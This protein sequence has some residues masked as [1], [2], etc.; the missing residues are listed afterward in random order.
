LRDRFPQIADGDKVVIWWGSVWKWLDA[1]TPI[2]AFAQIARSRSDVKFVITAGSPPAT[3]ASRFEATNSAVGLARDLGVADST[4]L[5][6]DEW[7]PYEQRY[8]YLGEASLGLTLH[9][10]AQEAAM[11]ARARYMDYLSAGLP[12]VL[13]RGDEVA[14]EFERAG[15]ATLVDSP[16]AGSLASTLLALLDDPEALERRR[17]AGM[18]LAE[19]RQWSAVGEQLRFTVG[20]IPPR[21]RRSLR[22]AAANLAEGLAYYCRR[23]ADEL[24]GALG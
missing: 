22:R 10:S 23:A 6:M 24:V 3:N 2:R 16:D 8:D 21:K 5:F 19:Q 13:G 12:C 4:V 7:I 9:R 18:R 1:E 17:S 14:E 11:A 20:S 15:Y